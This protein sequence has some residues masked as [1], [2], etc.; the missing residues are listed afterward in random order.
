MRGTNYGDQKTVREKS[1]QGGAVQSVNKG[2][3]G[4]HPRDKTEIQAN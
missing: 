1:I 4:M 2:A 3:K